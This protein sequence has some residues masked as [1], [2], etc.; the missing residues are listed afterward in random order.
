MEKTDRYGETLEQVI[1]RLSKVESHKGKYLAYSSKEV[2]VLATKYWRY[3]CWRKW[4]I[5]NAYR[6]LR[7][8][9]IKTGEDVFWGTGQPRYFYKPIWWWAIII[10]LGD[11]LESLNRFLAGETHD[12]T[13]HGIHNCL[14][15][16]M[17]NKVHWTIRKYL[18]LNYS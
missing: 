18:T 5:Q 9:N 14:R 17:Y 8:V 2:K 6:K 13:Q 4:M 3:Q 16:G 12:N 11:R 7:V 1:M 15:C 10:N